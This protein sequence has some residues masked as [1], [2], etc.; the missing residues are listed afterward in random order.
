RSGR[1]EYLLERKCR[2]AE[3]RFTAKH[4]SAVLTALDNERL[5]P[6]VHNFSRSAHEV[7][8]VGKHSRFGVINDENI[9]VLY[10][11]LHRLWFALNPEIHAVA[12][13]NARPLDLFQ[14]AE[15]KLRIDVAQED[16]LRRAIGIGNNRL[17]CLK[18]VE[19][20][21]QCAGF[22]E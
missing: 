6:H 11:S 8:L 15:L 2:R 3:D 10:R 17:E 14:H 21:V 18:H 7:W 9:D 22:V 1:I 5:W 19:L 16:I 20:S 13:D 4:Q 12:R